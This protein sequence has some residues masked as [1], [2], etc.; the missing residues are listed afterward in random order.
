MDRNSLKI[1]LLLIERLGLKISKA[2]FKEELSHYVDYLPIQSFSE[3]LDFFDLTTLKVM[4]TSKELH[5]IP[6]PAIAQVVKD[7]KSQFVIIDYV[8]S[9]KLTYSDDK[10]KQTNIG[11]DHFNEIWKGVALLIEIN[12]NS[13]EI[14]YLINRRKEIIERVLSGLIWSITLISII[15]FLASLEFILVL[16]YLIKISSVVTC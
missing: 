16:I 5:E 4:I 9:D 12:S 8:D 6:L 1:G 15:I 10:G 2:S 13:G 3:T 11:I 7:N 14:N